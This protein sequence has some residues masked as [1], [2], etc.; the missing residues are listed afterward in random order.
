MAKSYAYH[1]NLFSILFA[2]L[3]L[4]GCEGGKEMEAA[5]SGQVGKGKWPLKSISEGT[6]VCRWHEFVPG[7]RNPITRRPLILFKT[8][9]GRLYA[10]NGAAESAVAKGYVEAGSIKGIKVDQRLAQEVGEVLDAW[11]DI[12]LA[13]CEGDYVG[14][15]RL[16]KNA[17]R[18]ASR[19]M[20][21]GVKFE[22]SSSEDEMGRRRIFFELV[23]CQD[24]AWKA[25]GD[26]FEK[27][28]KLERA[29]SVK[30]QQKEALTKDELNAIATDG[31]SRRWSVPK[32]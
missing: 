22:L 2:L 30:I 23:Q 13:L 27:M 17:N 19:P 20:S 15:Q 28:R 29:C 21:A 6:I 31:I 10:I 8:T 1:M 32:W 12:G 7:S 18:I 16:A 26:N 9:S 24:G 3:V 5:V 4:S 14:A 11:L 25:A